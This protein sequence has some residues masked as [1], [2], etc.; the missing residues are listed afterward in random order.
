[1]P[2]IPRSYCQTLIPLDPT[3]QAR[4]FHPML[5]TLFWLDQ[6]STRP[7]PRCVVMVIAGSAAC[8]TGLCFTALLLLVIANIGR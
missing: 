7:G 3:S 5:P 4:S 6:Y 1:M 8:S 2:L